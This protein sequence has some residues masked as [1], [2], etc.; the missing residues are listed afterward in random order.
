MSEE[1]ARYRTMVRLLRSRLVDQEDC[2][3]I[4]HTTVGPIT[5]SKWDYAI[6]GFITLSGEDENHKY[7]FITFSEESVWR[8]PFEVKRK[9]AAASKETLGFKPA[10]QSSTEDQV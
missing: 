2:L 1:S 4:V 10:P 7:R 8:F 9:N 6:P 3:Y 5:I